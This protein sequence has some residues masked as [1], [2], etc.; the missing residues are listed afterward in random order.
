MQSGLAKGMH[1]AMKTGSKQHVFKSESTNLNSVC[2]IF[3]GEADSS[4]SFLWVCRVGTRSGPGRV[5]P[6]GVPM[7]GKAARQVATRPLPGPTTQQVR[8]PPA[9]SM[10][11]T[12]LSCIVWHVASA[13]MKHKTWRRSF[14]DAGKCA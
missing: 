13:S 1:L 3:Q 14:G 5:C 9:E 11:D 6:P 10:S 2:K 12:S 8:M 4:E 7:R